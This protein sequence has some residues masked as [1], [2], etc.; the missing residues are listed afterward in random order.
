MR[1][2]LTP[3]PTH[4]HTAQPFLSFAA[5]CPELDFFAPLHRSSSRRQSSL[6]LHLGGARQ[7]GEG[8]HSGQTH[9]PAAASAALLRPARRAAKWCAVGCRSL[10]SGAQ[11]PQ[12]PCSRVSASFETLGRPLR[13][14]APLC[15]PLSLRGLAPAACAPPRAGWRL[16]CSH[17]CCWAS[18][19][20]R[21]HPW[22]PA[23]PPP[24]PAPMSSSAASTQQQ[25]RRRAAQLRWPPTRMWG[26]SMSPQQRCAE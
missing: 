10:S 24:P 21:Q 9:V 19:W 18:C 23:P 7:A 16:A 14:P 15:L 3:L 13:P 25:R 4:L 2:A 20:L 6:A 26:P 11:R 12:R 5:S 8:Q 1:D 17:G 22:C